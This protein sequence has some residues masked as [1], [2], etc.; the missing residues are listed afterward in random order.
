MKN[1]GYLKAPTTYKYNGSVIVREEAST[2]RKVITTK[3]LSEGEHWIRF[4]SVFEGDDGKAQFM[5]DYFEIVPMTFILN[6]E[7]SLE[8]KRK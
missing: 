4:K 5:H 7:L 3:Y 1:R 6:E 8:E 2:I